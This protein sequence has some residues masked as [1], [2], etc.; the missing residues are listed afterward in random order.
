[1]KRIG[2]KMAMAVHIVA[3]H[4]GCSKRFVAVRLHRAAANGNNMKLGYSPVNRA[5]RDGLIVAKQGK[6]NS[7]KLYL[8]S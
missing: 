1:M 3:N 4:P 8:A 2:P 6:G 7:F 5:I